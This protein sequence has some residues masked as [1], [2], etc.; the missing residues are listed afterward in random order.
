MLRILTMLALTRICTAQES[1]CSSSEIVLQRYTNAVGGK[2]VDQIQTRTITAKQSTVYRGVTERWLYRF[3]WKAPNK[4]VAE[5]VPYLFNI[6]PA[7]YPNGA[8]IFDGEAWS[9]NDRRKSRNEDQDPAW[10]RELRHKYPYNEGPDFLMY[11]VIADPLLLTRA[12][13]LY[14]SLEPDRD[15]PA[16]LCVLRAYGTNEW[17][18]QREDILSFDAHTGLLK[19]WKIEAGVPTHKTYVEFQF[20]DYRKV[21]AVKYPF[22]IYFDFFKATFRYTKVVNNAAL[23]DSDFL[24]LPPKP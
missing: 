23:P 21:G 20:D 8:F 10:K 24:S 15:A 14:A 13:D 16:G 12:Q 4:V 7:S 22:Q 1:V 3:K 11:R 19:S 2:A 9:N 6:L 5:S 17:R 18:N